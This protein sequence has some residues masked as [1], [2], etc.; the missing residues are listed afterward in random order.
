MWSSDHN[1][2]CHWYKQ[3]EH[4]SAPR[5]LYTLGPGSLPP[6]GNWRKDGTEKCKG[7]RP[8]VSKGR[9]PKAATNFALRT[10]CLYPIGQNS[11]PWSLWP[12]GEAVKCSLYSE[13][14]R[15]MLWALSLQKEGITTV[16]AT[17]FKAFSKTRSSFGVAR[18]PLLPQRN[19]G[20]PLKYMF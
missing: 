19:S 2:S 18:V 6:A 13:Q 17:P 5:W 8:S 11:V 14:L 20:P 15:A 16:P 1:N 3:M 12:A 4:L 9:F 7:H 10:L